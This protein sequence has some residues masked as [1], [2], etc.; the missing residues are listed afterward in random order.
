MSDSNVDR[1]GRPGRALRHLVH[2]RVAPTLGRGFRD[3]RVR[4]KLMVL[5]NLFF[6]VLTTSVYFSLIPLFEERV[7]TAKAREV[8]LVSRMFTEERPP[9]QSPGIDFYDYREGTAAALD[10]PAAVQQWL[11]THPSEVHRGPSQQELLYYK[12]PRTAVYRRVTVPIKVYDAVLAR[13]RMALFLVL[14]TVYFLSVVVLEFLIMPQLVYLPLRL[15]LR[16]D[17]A[18][19]QGDRR[20]EVIDERY[21]T[22]DEIGQIMKSRNVTIRQLRR[23]EDDLAATLHR[24]EEVAADL[25]GKNKELQVAQETLVAQDR[26]VSLGLLSASVAH[27]LNTPLAVLQ[28]SIEKLAETLSGSATQDRLARML[29]V[30][31]RLRTISESL[32]DFARVRR[33]VME[34][35]PVR[36][37]VVEAWDLVAIDEKA[38]D[39]TFRNQVSPDAVVH[40]NAD[41]LTQVF[42]NLLR[43][44]LYAVTAAGEI[45]VCSRQVERDGQQWVDLTVEDNG[46]GIP[47]EVLPGIFDAFVSTRLDSKGTGL[48]LTVTQGI[49]QRHGG[50]IEAGN[51]PQGGACVQLLLPA[52]TG[53]KA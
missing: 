6:L 2:G 23:Q 13:A 20:S 12:D 48:G 11:D 24:L 35:V 28:G 32:L 7:T 18:T 34:A 41:R 25:K 42:V 43:N 50:T 21:L 36:P 29:R 17:A 4:P 52:E 49:V 14:G 45:V 47:P 40:G 1:S 8:G 15:M 37:L 33:E 10:I 16:A 39:V 51:R 53:A 3:L 26:L 44:A 19:Q 31:Q 30:T 22:D 46:P 38:T 9:L 5:H 27:E